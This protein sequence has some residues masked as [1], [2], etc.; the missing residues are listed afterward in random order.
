MLC[1]AASAICPASLP[2]AATLP[3]ALLRCAQA[4][5]KSVA[6]STLMLLSS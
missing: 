3:P 2:A 4:T 5:A 6:K 1:S